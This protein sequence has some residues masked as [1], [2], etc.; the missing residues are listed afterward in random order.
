M[1]DVSLLDDEL[2]G[3]IGRAAEATQVVVTA[4]AVKRAR[5][6]YFG[7]VAPPPAEGDEVE[8]VVIA[9]LE[10]STGQLRVPDVMPNSVLISNEWEFERPLRAGDALTAQSRLA[11][12]TERFGGQFGY[13]L[14]FR[15]EVELRDATGALVARTATTLMQYDARN[16]RGQGQ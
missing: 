14:Y 7:V 5:E 10:T 11:D 9:A 4:T 13:S 3:M 15:T 2:K 8:G 1:T 12:I 6:V 16:A